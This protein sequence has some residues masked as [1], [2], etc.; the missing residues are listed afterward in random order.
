M[1]TVFPYARIAG[2]LLLVMMMIDMVMTLVFEG[3]GVDVV[4][5]VVQVLWIVF[6]ALLIR[7]SAKHSPVVP[8]SWIAIVA[9]SVGIL[10]FCISAFFRWELYHYTS[11]TALITVSNVISLVGR[12]VAFIWLS[13]YFPRG[14]VLQVMCFL[15]AILPVFLLVTGFLTYYWGVYPE[16]NIVFIRNIVRSLATY[17]PQIIFLFAFSKLKKSS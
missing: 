7:A 14:S 4:G 2:I 8:P 11:T 10:L 9:F 17:V 16:R 3:T 6:F 15:I 12:A 5:L 13:R 1:K